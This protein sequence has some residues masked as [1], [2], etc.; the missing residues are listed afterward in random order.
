MPDAVFSSSD[1]GAIGALQEVRSAGNGKFIPKKIVLMPELI[2]RASSLKS[3]K[4]TVDSP[5]TAAV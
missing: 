1:L 2:I 3:A 5:L 4:S